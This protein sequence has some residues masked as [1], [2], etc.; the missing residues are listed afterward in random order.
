VNL[1]DVVYVNINIMSICCLKSIYAQ[2]AL[3]VMSMIKKLEK[4]PLKL[5]VTDYDR[6]KKQYEDR[7]PNADFFCV[8]FGGYFYLMVEY[9]E[10]KIPHRS[11]EDI[12]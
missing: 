12:K 7:Y 5:S 8:P 10:I 2:N 1:K 3:I 4:L 6:V 9:E 11:I